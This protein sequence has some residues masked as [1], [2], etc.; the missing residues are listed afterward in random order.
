M[1]KIIAVQVAPENQESELIRCGFP[2]FDEYYI[3]VIITG[4]DSY[5]GYTTKAY[6]MVQESLVNGCEHLPNYCGEGLAYR[7]ITEAVHDCFPPQHKNKYSTFDIKAW[8]KL[9]DDYDVV[10]EDGTWSQHEHD[11]TCRALELMT[12]K[13]YTLACIR[14]CSQGDWQYVLYPHEEVS[15]KA[16]RALESEYFNTGTEWILHDDI[17]EEDLDEDSFPSG[18]GGGYSVYC[19]ECGDDDRRKE[20]ASY[21]GCGESDLVMYRFEGFRQT[22]IYKLVA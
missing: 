17:S 6:D 2:H 10:C 4:N 19:H 14:G 18:L 9:F 1:G 20:L 8:K 3:D 15:E 16:I 22:P 5:T 7:N 21:I 11:I 13:P 12:G